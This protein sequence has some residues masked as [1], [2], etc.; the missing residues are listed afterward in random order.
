M[1]YPSLLKNLVLL[2]FVGAV[3]SAHAADPT[4]GFE[5]QLI[6]PPVPTE[7]GDKIEVVELFWYGCPHCYH[8]EPV[9]KQWL[10]TK[11]DNVE[12][13]QVPAVFNEL[14]ALHARA[15][16]TAEALGV[17]DKVHEPIFVAYHE[18]NNRLKDEDALAKL[19]ALYGVSEEDF[20]K[21]FNSFYIDIKVRRAKA[22]SKD[23]GIDGVPAMVVNGKY[24]TSGTLAG[25]QNQVMDVV[26]YLIGLESASSA[27]D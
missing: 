25:G 18:Q 13:R 5:Y 27:Q 12:L 20:R 7:T 10:R 21:T 4:E 11:P 17:L 23:Y 2:L 9:V 1:H 26:D 16:Y 8:F 24:R 15:F 6:Q 3:S 19:F 22:L 14:W